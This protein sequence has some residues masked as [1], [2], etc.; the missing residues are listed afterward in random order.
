M[1]KPTMSLV[2]TETVH[3][4][5]DKTHSYRPVILFVGAT[6][7]A[8]FV[9]CKVAPFKDEDDALSMAATDAAGVEE[10]VEQILHNLGYFRA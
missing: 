3:P 7:M 9:H 10:S 4:G 8:R 6:G 5:T 1:T 2:T